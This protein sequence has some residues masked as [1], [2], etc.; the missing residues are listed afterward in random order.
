M[1]LSTRSHKFDD[2]VSKRYLPGTAQTLRRSVVCVYVWS[3]AKANTRDGAEREED[4][5]VIDQVW[6]LLQL[7]L[8]NTETHHKD[9]THV[10][11]D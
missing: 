1:R 11:V 2:K 7:L 4:S 3:Q 5:G 6:D 10:Q 9:C 8:Q